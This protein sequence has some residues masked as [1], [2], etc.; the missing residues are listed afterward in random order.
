MLLHTTPLPAI[1]PEIWDR[2]LALSATFVVGSVMLRSPS[3]RVP[4]VSTRLF[5]PRYLPASRQIGTRPEPA[6][7]SR[8]SEA[9]GVS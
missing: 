2:D 9:Y 6:R 8:V 3:T 7:A 1:S 5:L 4:I